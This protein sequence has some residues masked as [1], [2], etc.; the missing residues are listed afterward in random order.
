MATRKNTKKLTPA[1]EKEIWVNNFA[2]GGIEQNEISDEL[3]ESMRS[4]IS[5]QL[6]ERALPYVDGLKP[7]HKRILWCMQDRGYRA[8]G[9]YTKAGTVSGDIMG[10]YH[11]HADPYPVMAKMTRQKADDSKTGLCELNLCLVD[12]HGNFGN[13]FKDSPG[14]SRYTEVRLSQNGEACTR[15]VKDN[16]VYMIPTYTAVDAEPEI[17]PVRIP[18]LLING[19]DGLAYG[20]NTDWMPHNPSEALNACIYRLDNPKCSSAEIKDILPGP[21]FPSGGIVIDTEGADNGLDMAISTGFGRFSISSRYNIEPLTRGRYAIEFYQ[22]P[23]GIAQQEGKSIVDSILVFA[24][25]YPEYRIADVKCLTGNENNGLIEVTLK[26]GANPEVVAAALLK[27]GATLLTTKLGYRQ[28]M[29]TC[30]FEKCE[31]PDFYEIKNKLRPVSPLPKDVSVLDYIDEFIKFRRACVINSCTFRK[32]KALSQKHLIDGLLIALI[33]IDEVIKVVRTSDDKNVAKTKLM[34]KFK[35]DGEQADYVLSLTLSRLTKSDK[36]DLQGRSKELEALSKEL[37]KI[38]SSEKNIKAEIRRQLVEELEKQT[39]PR[40]TT[41]IS[42]NGKLIASGTGKKT[43]PEGI[44]I[45]NIVLGKSEVCVPK[46]SSPIEAVSVSG[47]VALTVSQEGLV[48][49]PVGEPQDFPKQA[50]PLEKADDEVVFFSENGGSMRL[51]GYDINDSGEL[52]PIGACVGVVSYAEDGKAFLATA[53]GKVKILDMSTLTKARECPAI[54]LADGDRVIFASPIAEGDVVALVTKQAN[55]LT[56]GI[57]KV[58]SQGRTSGGVN[59]IS[60]KADDEVIAAWCGTAEA[61]VL[62]GTDG[63]NAKCSLLSDFPPK[64]RATGGVRCHAMK[65]GDNILVTAA[66]GEK[67]GFLNKTKLTEP[68]EIS[69][70]DATGTPFTGDIISFS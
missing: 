41:I 32:E 22:T 21:D 2:E 69:K 66:V 29:V 65:K 50:L 61:K 17:L 19:S 48:F 23:F 54:S 1:E 30:N 24:E 45:A 59:G 60:L 5:Y 47:P 68:D 49:R 3:V 28:S 7:V 42:A 18:L 6:T 35:L 55:L 26:N 46:T 37:G 31:T 34:K 14:A 16:A 53:A 56:F 15:D 9:G 70:R 62:T 57:E 36:I 43:D 4:Y 51:H 63:G 33:D 67:V 39:L 38:L 8:S 40:R 10:H 13:G 64:G 44:A 58:P 52:L 12:G 20:Y 25:K 11:P 27:P